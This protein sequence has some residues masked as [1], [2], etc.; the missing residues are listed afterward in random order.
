MQ[1]SAQLL[2]EQDPSI[3]LTCRGVIEVSKLHLCLS[4]IM[5]LFVVNKT[6]HLTVHKSEFINNIF[7]VWILLVQVKGKGAMTTYWVGDPKILRFDDNDNSQILTTIE[8]G[9]GIPKHS[10]NQVQ[11]ESK[12]T[13][14]S[15]SC[16]LP[17]DESRL[18]IEPE[19]QLKAE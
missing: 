8:Q 10:K 18:E 5:V 13:F 15:E 16:F 14:S 6:L 9:H 12:M 3:Q 11:V 2:A 7:T 1:I 17:I 4:E 19:G